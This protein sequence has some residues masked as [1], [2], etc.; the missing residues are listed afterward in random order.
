[1]LTQTDI[2]QDE[3]GIAIVRFS[4]RLTTGSSMSLAE[5]KIDDLIDGQNIRKMIFDLTSVEYMDSTGLAFIVYTHGKLQKSGGQLRL[6]GPN[7]RV[8]EMFHITHTEGLLLIDS[9]TQ[10]ST[11][12]LKA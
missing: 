9:D 6:S 3:N 2:H 12:K 1:M 7:A 5:S 4:G 10:E 11:E 8:L